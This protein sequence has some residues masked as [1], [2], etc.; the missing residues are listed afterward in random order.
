MACPTYTPSPTETARDRDLPGVA[1]AVTERRTTSPLA[2]G[3]VVR[4]TA[5]EPGLALGTARVGARIA[6]VLAITAL[7]WV[8][9]VRTRLATLADL[10]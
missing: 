2:G 3:H 9:A 10:A 1:L 5:V 6:P 4:R 7:C 8:E